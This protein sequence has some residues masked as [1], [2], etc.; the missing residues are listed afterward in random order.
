MRKALLTL[1]AALILVIASGCV[2]QKAFAS[3]KPETVLGTQQIDLDKDGAPDVLVY[4]F[5]PVK[6]NGMTERRQVTVAAHYAANYTSHKN[7]TD[8]KLLEVRSK[9]DAF[10]SNEVLSFEGCAANAGLKKDCADIAS[11][12]VLCTGSYKCE[13]ILANYPDAVGNSMID[14]VNRRNRLE[15][16]LLEARN[17][18]LT[19][20]TATPEQKDAYLNKLLG[21]KGEVAELYSN[22]FYNRQEM[23]LC[24]RSEFGL[25]EAMDAAAQIGDYAPAVDHYDYFV[26]LSVTGLADQENPSGVALADGLPSSFITSDND[27]T[28]YLK[29]NVEQNASAYSIIWESGKPSQAGVML[30]Y[31]FS[32]ARPPEQVAAGFRSPGISISKMDLTMFVLPNALFTLIYGLTSNFFISLGAALSLTLIILLIAYNLATTGYAVAKAVM[33][34]DN[35]MVGL[36]KA[37]GRT[38]LRWKN[39]LL[40]AVFLLAAGYYLSAFMVPAGEVPRSM[41][42]AVD[43]FAG[44][45]LSVPAAAGLAGVSC[46]FL[47]VL[48]TYTAIENKVRVTILEKAY[49][50]V[51]KEEKDIFTARASR[52]REKVIELQRLVDTCS[53]NEFDVSTEYDVLAAVP[54]QRLDD[55]SRKMSPDSRKAIDRALSNVEDALERLAERKRMADENWPK[56]SDMIDKILV[57]QGEVYVTSLITVPASMRGWALARYAKEHGPEGVVA[58]RDTIKKKL[59]T[60]DTLVRAMMKDGLLEGAIVVEKDQVTVAQMAQGT[61]TVAAVLVMKLR[62]YLHSTARALGQPD[63]S[64]FAVVGEKLVLVL[65]REQDK[66]TVLY[67]P[68]EKFKDVIDEWKKRSRLLSTAE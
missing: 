48:L 43:Y 6:V 57:E 1:L 39:D 68:R 37:F 9:L 47:G 61:G 5:A 40:L 55:L 11:C 63:V 36:R 21:V 33:A 42:S 65:L 31:K 16:M 32:S 58:E 60:P 41:F 51:I 59:V 62:S 18:V 34:G 54:P 14:F 53:K 22:P 64:S 27:I 12:S 19:L 7:L 26:T 10:A 46:I 50:I 67:I 8:L 24:S 45:A 66:D 15:S 2:T 35:A 3:G 20:R 52:L 23:L 49:G 17:A 13:K 25:P 44:L 28:S 56:W 30:A 4:D 29:I 38:E